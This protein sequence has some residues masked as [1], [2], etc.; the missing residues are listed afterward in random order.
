MWLELEPLPEPNKGTKVEPESKIKISAP[1]EQQGWYPYL[2]ARSREISKV[3]RRRLVQYAF[4][5]DLS[6]GLKIVI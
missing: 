4:Q 6:V 1:L 5:Q 3:W 2:G